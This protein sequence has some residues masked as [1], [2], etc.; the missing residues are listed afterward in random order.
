MGRHDELEGR[1]AVVTGGASGLGFAIATELAH[2]GVH[3]ALLD[4]DAEAAESAAA[5]L[6]ADGRVARSYRVDVARSADVDDAFSAVVQDFGHLD[7]AVNNAGI[8]RVGP[9]THEVTDDDWA[10]S[11][12]VMQ[13]GVFYGMRA[14]GRIM[15]EQGNGSII[16]IASIRGF[17]PNPG[18]LAY[19]AAKAA[20]IMMTRVA[21]GEW[22]GEGVRVNAVAPGVMRTPMWDLGVRQGTLDEPTYLS[23]V[24]AERIGD[25]AEVGELVAFLASDRCSY[26]TG[27]VVTIDGGLTSIP[28]G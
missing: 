10:A 5:K 4:V 28:A 15:L 3:V 1:T 7:I 23:T 13:S 8:S 12:G 18:R 26:M 2:K 14:A 19:C 17:S 24:P 25:P 11:I 20:V 21:A 22:A 9:L 16:N 27:A 6:S